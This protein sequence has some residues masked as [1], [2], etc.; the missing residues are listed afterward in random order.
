MGEEGRC[1]AGTATCA[2]QVIVLDMNCSLWGSGLAVIH[3]VRDYGR[4]FQSVIMTDRP[5][6]C[7]GV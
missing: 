6:V 4:R 7:L 3:V 2:L 1:R 5:C